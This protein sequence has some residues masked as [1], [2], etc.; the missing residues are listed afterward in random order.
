MA[1]VA[2]GALVL[3]NIDRSAFSV[4]LPELQQRLALSPSQAGALQVRALLPG[5]AG[6]LHA[7]RRA[8]A[9]VAPALAGP[10]DQL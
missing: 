5:H 10:A 4:L 6:R 8:Q 9:A 2:A 3:C 1:G 7:C